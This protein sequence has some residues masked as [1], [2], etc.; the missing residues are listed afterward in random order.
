MPAMSWL[1]LRFQIPGNMLEPVESWLEALGA[2]SVTLRDAEDEP[3][4]EPPPGALPLWR[5]IKVEALFSAETDATAVRA[6]LAK[7][8]GRAPEAWSSELLRDQAWERTWMDQFEPMR[9][10]RRLWIVPSWHE[11]PDAGAV[12]LLLD[13][14]L[15]FGTGTH[16]TTALCLEWLDAH[17]PVEASVLDFGCG[18]GVLAL[19]AL[20][21]DARHLV[22]VDIDEQALIAS[23]DNVE[24]NGIPAD[25]LS[26]HLA[27]EFPEGDQF[28]LVMANILAEPLIGLAD[29]LVSHI[30]PGG[31]IILSGIL[32]EQADTVMAAYA[33][34]VQ[35]ADVRQREDWVFLHGKRRVD[36]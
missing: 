23:R 24:R 9:F 12:N 1:Q 5:H 7:R 11:P 19:A 20:K 35:F 3:L 14:G 17:P 13:P 30:R 25:R 8:M 34:M 21:L 18:S 15:A 27:D 2:L 22:G 29:K 26:L 28:D 6:E 33:P 36:S 31:E 32:R 4:F 10:G 16:P